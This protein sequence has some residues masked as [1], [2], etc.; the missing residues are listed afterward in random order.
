MVPP[1]FGHGL[2]ALCPVTRETAKP[3]IL[4][5]CGSGATFH[6]GFTKPCTSQL[7]SLHSPERTP[8]LLCLSCLTVYANFSKKSRKISRPPK[9]R[10]MGTVSPWSGRSTEKK[11]ISA[12]PAGCLG[13][14]GSAPPPPA[15]PKHRPPFPPE[16]LPAPSESIRLQRPDLLP[17][18]PPPPAA[19]SPA[20]PSSQTGGQ[21]GPQ[22]AA[23]PL[24]QKKRS[25]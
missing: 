9:I 2:P 12:L 20:G 6:S 15:I 18:L 16:N 22:N 1:E 8:P 24:H 14:G 10:P 7:L 21:P 13:N 25:Q 4:Q 19:P 17:P 23:Y 11:Q 3:T 5:L